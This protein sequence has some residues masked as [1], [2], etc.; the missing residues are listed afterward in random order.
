ME[1]GE[2]ISDFAPKK[3]ARQLDF[4]VCR[5]SANAILSE[6]SIKSHSQPQQSQSHP[7]SQKE[8]E[9]QVASLPQP[10]PQPHVQ[11]QLQPESQLQV[12]WQI[13][14]QPQVTPQWQARPQQAAMMHRIPHPVQKLQMPTPHMAKQE[15]PRSQPRGNNEAKDGTP[16]KHKQCNCRNSR[17]LKLYCE[18]FAAGIFCDGCNCVNCHNNVE[19]EAAR[20]EAVETTLERNPHAFRPKIASSPHASQD[21]REDARDA[22]LAVKH[23]KGCHCK[24][25]GCLKK[26]CECF[27]ANILCSENCKCLD[28]KNFEGSEERRALFHGDHNAIAFMQRAA[29]AAISG[30]IGSSGYGTPLAMKKR[31]CEELLFGVAAKDQSIKRNAPCQQEHHLRNSAVSPIQS[32]PVSRSTNTAISGSSKFTYRSPLADILQP[33]DMKDLCSLLVVFSSKATMTLTEKIGEM[34]TKTQRNNTKTDVASSTQEIE[35]SKQ[36]NAFNNGAPNDPSIGNSMDVEERSG[37]GADG[38]DMQNERPLSPGTRALMCD[39][40]DT[41]FMA[42]GSPT[43]LAGCC[44]STTQK[45]NGHECTRIYA[46]QERIILTAF[47]DILNDLITVGSIKETMCSPKRLEPVENGTMKAGMEMKN[48]KEPCGNS[49]GKPILPAAVE[50]SQT[51]A[52]IT[53]TCK[54][55]LLMKVGLPIENEKMDS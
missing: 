46:E 12:Q 16:K 18:C 24:K 48:H 6:Q 21:A 30:A 32:V 11:L 41:M 3:L 40:E 8:V 4:T 5:A 33:Q 49:T 20:K 17:C 15:S 28:C 38:C 14:S 51:P 35:D 44:P 45:Y 55:D 52:T 2:K 23:N 27:Q 36:G 43:G 34:D 26:Y 37:S 1:Q 22:Q 42:A 25:S 29:N 19:H 54:N 31:K 50:L 10:Q 47:R 9:L 7:K 13:R 53:S 39:E